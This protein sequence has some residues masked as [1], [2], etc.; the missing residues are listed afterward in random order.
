MKSRDKKTVKKSPKRIKK[1]EKIRKS[2][3]I[4]NIKNKNK[5]NS[6]NAEKINKSPTVNKGKDGEIKK[7]EKIISKVFKKTKKSS[8]I[9]N[10][11]KFLN[12]A[13][14]IGI[15]PKPIE[16]I[17]SGPSKYILMEKLD[18]TL[19]D[20]M[21]KTGGLS[22]EYQKE[23]IRILHLLDKNKIFHGDISP[24]NFMTKKGDKKLYIIDF[25]MS[26][27][28]TPEFI[29]EHS[30]HANVKMGITV[31]ILKLRDLVPT[32]DP[33]LLKNEVFKYLKI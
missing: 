26:H 28:M 25:G 8:D 9:E 27:D 7:G 24:L 17:S 13:Y 12:K 33:I 14:N 29:K 32:F 4:K 1:V 2:P 6:D 11:Y 22:D 15:A 30:P 21:K 20:H 3:S 31:F 19:F 16:C 23:M 18:E 5:N 10:E